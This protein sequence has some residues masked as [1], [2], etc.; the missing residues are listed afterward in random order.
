MHLCTARHQLLAALTHTS[1]LH[2]GLLLLHANLLL[3]LLL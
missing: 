2:G 1:R 3:L